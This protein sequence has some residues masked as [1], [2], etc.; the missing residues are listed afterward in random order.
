MNHNGNRSCFLPR[1]NMNDF[2][3]FAMEKLKNIPFSH[4]PNKTKVLFKVLFNLK[5]EAR[6]NFAKD[7]QKSND[8]TTIQVGK[9]LEKALSVKDKKDIPQIFSEIK[10]LLPKIDEK[11]FQEILISPPPSN[12]SSR[13]IHK[14]PLSPAPQKPPR[15]LSNNPVRR[16]LFKSA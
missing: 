8:E 11:M 13:Q 7:L 6:V 15:E 3:T 14:R 1:M 10:E 5:D 9:I 2:I 12:S 16:T 4:W